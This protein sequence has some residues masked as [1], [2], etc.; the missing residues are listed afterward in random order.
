MGGCKHV[1]DHRV[2]NLQFK[3]EQEGQEGW[4]Q[5]LCAGGGVFV[6]VCVR[7]CL[8]VCVRVC[9]CLRACV[10]WWWSVSMLWT[11]GS[12]TCSSSTSK[13]GKRG[14]ARLCVQGGG[15]VFV[16]VCVRVCVCVCG[17]GRLLVQGGTV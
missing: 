15:V 9:V 17:G 12:S 5:A 14:V 8:C 6:C 1:V 2:V 10:W 16:C 7:V 11:T 3:Y 4:R 13:R